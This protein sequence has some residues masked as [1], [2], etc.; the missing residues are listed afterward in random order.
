MLERG[1]GLNQSCPSKA[2]LPSALSLLS[3]SH[4]ACAGLAARMS[5]QMRREREEQRRLQEEEADFERVMSLNLGPMNSLDGEQEVRM[6]H[7]PWDAI[8]HHLDAKAI[9][10]PCHALSYHY[11]AMLWAA[12]L[13]DIA[14][15]DGS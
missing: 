8:A 2:G 6:A 10:T 7:L 4:D 3:L 1:T 9:L 14:A 5:T 11:H 15:E 13:L 12:A